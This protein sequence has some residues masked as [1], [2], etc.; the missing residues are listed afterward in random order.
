MQDYRRD[1]LY[2]TLHIKT[3]VLFICGKKDWLAGPFHYKEVKFPNMLLF[4]IDASHMLFPD[5]IEEVVI[6]I[7]KYNM[8]YF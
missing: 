7:I 5:N 6:S 2:E 8:E 3:P 4:E 1:F